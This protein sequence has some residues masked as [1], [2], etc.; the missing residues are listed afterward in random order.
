MTTAQSKKQ[1]TASGKLNLESSADRITEYSL[2]V[3]QSKYDIYSYNSIITFE[4]YQKERRYN[5]ETFE[6]GSKQVIHHVHHLKTLSFVFN[7]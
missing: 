5:H 1:Y 6:D 7:W 3:I 4:I 2:F